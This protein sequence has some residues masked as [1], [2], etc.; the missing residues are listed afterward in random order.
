MA[1]DEDVELCLAERPAAQHR[2]LRELRAILV[3]R[4]PKG[5]EEVTQ[6]TMLA[7][8]VPHSLYPAGYHTNPKQPLPF[9]SLAGQ[10]SGIS[11]HH[12]GMYET[13]EVAAW[14]RGRVPKA[15]RHHARHGQELY[16]LQEAR[17]GSSHPHR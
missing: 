7:Y 10:K 2:A 9:I 4:L 17:P 5:F 1:S 8:V 11:L 3:S 16:P 13:A 12:F 6:G 14:L 15:Q